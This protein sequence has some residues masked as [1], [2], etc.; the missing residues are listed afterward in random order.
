[1]HR[2]GIH[3]KPKKGGSPI[4]NSNFF[5]AVLDVD[6]VLHLPFLRSSRA[7]PAPPTVVPP[8][9]AGHALVEWL[10]SLFF[11]LSTASK[12]SC[13]FLR[14]STHASF[15]RRER[16]TGLRLKVP[17]AFWL[18]EQNRPK[19]LP[20][21]RLKVD[22]SSVLIKLEENSPPV[23]LDLETDAREHIIRKLS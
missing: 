8:R 9:D 7:F 3:P 12:L 19:N 23:L 2:G 5:S 13:V 17:K 21:D 1:M 20:L 18:D 14:K 16:G 11:V 22:G 6:E 4:K 15:T 10:A